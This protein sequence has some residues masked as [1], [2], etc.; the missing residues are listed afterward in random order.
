MLFEVPVSSN[1][2][3]Q[4]MYGQLLSYDLCELRKA[5]FHEL[6]IY[7]EELKAAKRDDFRDLV[8]HF[9]DHSFPSSLIKIGSLT[10]DLLKLNFWWN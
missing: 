9:K 7:K 2:V 10:H 4:Q 1:Y 8:R 3:N 5:H 6:L